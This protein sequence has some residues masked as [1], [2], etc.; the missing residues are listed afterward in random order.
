MTDQGLVPYKE[1]PRTFGG[2]PVYQPFGTVLSISG[3]V[4]TTAGAVLNSIGGIYAQTA[5]GLWIISNLIF[6]AYFIG[7]FR[8]RWIVNSDS[9]YMI[10]MYAV[11]LC[12]SMFG[13]WRA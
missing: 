9:K 2:Y 1:F 3:T 13:Y 5:F 10:L 11:F 8:K 7:V 12:S 6:M 4:I